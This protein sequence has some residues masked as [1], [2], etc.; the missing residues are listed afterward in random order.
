MIIMNLDLKLK[1]QC[2]NVKKHNHYQKENNGVINNLE[3][4]EQLMIGI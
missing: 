2:L 3:Q 1:L 4:Q